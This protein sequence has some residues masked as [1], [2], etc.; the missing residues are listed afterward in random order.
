MKVNRNNTQT[1]ATTTD[2]RP[3]SGVYPVIITD[4]QD[5]PG[6]SHL[7]IW[8]DFADGPYK[9][10]Y[11]RL[12]QEHPDWVWLGMYRRYYTPSAMWAFDKLCNAVSRSNGNFAF[13]G[14]K[15]NSD[16]KTLIG[17]RMGLVIRGK[18]YY[19]NSGD[20]SIKPDVVKE[21]PVDRVPYE[22]VPPV[23]TIAKQEELKARRA[24]RQS[25]P[26]PAQP[27]P[28]PA[29]APAQAFAQ[30]SQTVQPAQPAQ[31]APVQTQPVYQQAQASP[32]G[33][34]QTQTQTQ[35][36]ALAGFVQV[37]SGSPDQMPFA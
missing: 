29:P 19:T 34:Q 17:K 7:K 22:P 26:A 16:E 12:R 8:Y 5:C 35:Q 30:Q 3:V 15:V 31:V 25:T 1:P 37:P 14:D 28:A 9:G 24:A 21:V 27:A 13:D 11:T 32:T 33:Y 2:D 10:Y 4:V 18:E 20:L 6:E 36:Q 23:L